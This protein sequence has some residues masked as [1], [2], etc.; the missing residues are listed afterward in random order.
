MCTPGSK[1]TTVAT[2]V[3]SDLDLFADE[4]LVD[5][6]PAYARLRELGGA[7]YLPKNDAHNALL[8]PDAFHL[9]VGRPVTQKI[10]RDAAHPSRLVLPFTT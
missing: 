2:P 6:Y 8:P 9:P 10:Y 4:V 3:A 7:V 5:P 1:A